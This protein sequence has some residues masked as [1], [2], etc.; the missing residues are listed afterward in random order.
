M[1][2]VDNLEFL[3]SNVGIDGVTCTNE[4][5]DAYLNRGNQ[6]WRK[7]IK[8]LHINAYEMTP[9][10]YICWLEGKLPELMPSSRRQYIASTRCM[11][12]AMLHQATDDDVKYELMTTLEYALAMKSEKYNPAVPTKKPWRGNTSSQKSKKFSDEEFEL[13]LSEVKKLKWKWSMYAAVWIAANRLVGLRPSEWRNVVLKEGNSI[14]LEVGN[15]KHTNGRA[16]GEFRHIDITD[17]SKNELVI[18][19]RQL[20]L[21]SK[22]ATTVADWNAYYGGVRQAIYRIARRI[23]G[24]QRKYLSFYS[25]RHQ[26]SADAKASGMSKAEV[27][28]LMGHASDKT[29]TS[30]YGK[31][32]HGG[33][34][35]RVK[36]DANEVA[37]VRIKIDKSLHNSFRV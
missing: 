26:F 23:Q 22:F 11:L 29:A 35:F 14:I 25:T 17:L 27:A 15:G 19:K 10:K 1:D 18:I 33:S 31:K 20:K 9:V 5:I 36:P 13:F 28:A 16:N 24:D 12:D 37:T 21:A 3:N 32:K 7:A 4:T 2:N 34:G 8:E 30:H 6:L